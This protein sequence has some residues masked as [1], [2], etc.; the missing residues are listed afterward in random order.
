LFSGIENIKTLH[1]GIPTLGKS[2]PE[3]VW[4]HSAHLA[5]RA[6][7]PAHDIGYA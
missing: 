2:S 1:K 3:F 7:T 6:V 4:Q 5:N